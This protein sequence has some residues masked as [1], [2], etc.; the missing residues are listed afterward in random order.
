MTFTF[1]YIFAAI[2]I[3][4][5]SSEFPGICRVQ[6]ESVF[7]FLKFMFFITIYRMVMH[8][9]IGFPQVDSN[10]S[11]PMNTINIF[12]T[13]GVYWEDAIFTLPALIAA[14]RG[15]SKFLVSCMLALSAF[16]FASGHIDYGLQWAALTLLYIPFI[17]YKY[18]KLNG[19]GTVMVCHI[20]YD[21][22]TLA[23]VRYLM[24]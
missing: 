9:V 24:L 7:K 15:S 17:S 23:T 18:G 12:T 8:Y 20:L 16:V 4:L 3:L 11:S 22:I 6:K 1:L 19:L 2:F 13:L 21:I 14:R 5:A 10:P